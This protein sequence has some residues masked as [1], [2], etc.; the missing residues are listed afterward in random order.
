MAKFALG[1]RR[2]ALTFIALGAVLV[3]AVVRWN[4]GGGTQAPL[5]GV[6]AKKSAV[7]G[8]ASIEE[9]APAARGGRRSASTKVLSP[10]EVPVIDPKDFDA[11]TGEGAFRDRPRPLRSPRADSAS[12]ADAHAAAADAGRAELHRSA[13]PPPPT[14]TPRPPE[15]SFKF[16]GSFGPKDRP[17][18]VVQQGDAVFNARA[19][20]T[21]FGKFVLRKVGYESIDVGFVGFDPNETRRLPITP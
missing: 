2:Q 16:L 18:A 13:P 10:D 20:D 15:I 19:G 17:I 9:E 1:T 4:S 5:P 6:P 7:S 21:L 14:P 8:P 11:P 12:A 3:L